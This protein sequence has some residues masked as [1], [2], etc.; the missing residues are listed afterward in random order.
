MVCNKLFVILKHTLVVKRWEEI[1]ASDLNSNKPSSNRLPNNR[2]LRPAKWPLTSRTVTLKPPLTTTPQKV[3]THLYSQM[4]KDL[5]NILRVFFRRNQS[6][7]DE[8]PDHLKSAD[9]AS[10]DVL[11]LVVRQQIAAWLNSGQRWGTHVRWCGYA[12][13]F[14]LRRSSESKWDRHERG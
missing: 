11:V 5:S 14:D 13:L 3:S 10:N 4:R 6:S 2:R 7:T 1:I 9:S 8:A 12:Y